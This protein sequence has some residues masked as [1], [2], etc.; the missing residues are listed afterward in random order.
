M[1]L[2]PNGAPP[3]Y[4]YQAGATAYLMD[5]AGTYSV[6]GATAPTTD[7]TGA[8]SG[9]GASAPTLAAAGAYIPVTDATSS[10]AEVIDPAGAYSAAGASAP[11]TDPADAYNRPGASAPTLAAG[12][13]DIPVAGATSASVSPPGTYLPAGASAP[14]P[15]PP[16]TYSGAGATAPTQ[17]PAGT[18]SGPYALDRLILDASNAA[19]TNTVLPFHSV[20]AVE[21]YFG[22]TSFE[23]SLAS[24]FFA[25]YAGS[26]AT[27][28]I[29]RYSLG[30]ERAHLFGANISKLKLSQL[31][32]ISG[33]LSIVF[34]GWAYS[35][36]I[37]LSGV[38]SFSAAAT[39]IQSA[40]N[41]SAPVAAMTSGSS[42][43]PVSVSFKGSLD[44]FLLRVT[45]V[46]SGRIEL[47]AQFSGPGIA[48]GAEIVVQNNGTPGG[49]GLYTLYSP[50]GT[51]SS[52][53]MTES[54]GV[55]TVGSV[56]SG[57]VADGEEVTGPGVASLTAIDDNL[58]GSGA[59]STWL[60]NNAQTVAPE[61]MT[62]TAT[63]LSVSYKSIVG[64][65]ANRDYFEVSTNGAFGF[66]QNPSSLS[67]MGGSA[68]A[69]LGLTQ[70]SEALDSTPGGEPTSAAAYMNN[71][72]QN[73][74]SQFGSF[75]AIWPQLAREDPEYL[76]DLAAWAQ[77]TDGL[78]QFSS[79][80]ETTTAAGSS[81][82]TPDPA[83]TYSGADASAPTPAAAGTYIPGTGATSAAAEITNSPGTYSLAGASAPTRAQPGYYVP[84]PGASSETPV[85]QGYY[86]P[87]S[88]ATKELLA[89][90]PTISGT[91]AGQTTGSGQPD[92]PFSSV[93]IKSRN[94][95]AS[96]S[97]SIQIT[98]GGGALADSAGFSGLTESAAGV[99]LLSGTDSAITSELDALV[100][101]PNTFSATTTLTLTDTT[102][103]G[104]SATDANTTVTVTNGEPVVVSVSTFLAEESTLNQQNPHG[105]D[106]L[107]SAANITAKLNQLD[108]S[109]ITAITIS[110]NG[111]VGASIQQLTTKAT[112]KAIGKLRNANLS[113]ALLAI[114]DTT[115]DI[116]AG[117]STLVAESDKIA[118][119]TASNGPMV[120]WAVTFLADQ[121]ALD[122]IVGGF[123]VLGKAANLAADLDRLNDP[124][125]S[126]ITISDNGEISASVAQL[127]AD[128]TAIGDLQNANGSSV[129]L[130][131]HDT[132][133]D[134]QTGLST[135]VQDAGEIGSITTSDGPIV[136]SVATFQDDQAALDKIVGGFDV[137][138]TAANIVANLSSLN[139]NSY[140]A[141][142][143]VDIGEASLSGGAVVN[144]RSFSESGWGTSLTVS[145]ALAYAG[146]FSQGA[147]STTTITAGNTLSLT[148]TASLSGTTSGLGTL[149]LAGGSATINSGAAVSVADLSISGSGAS[150]TL[151]EALTYAGAFSE[152][153]GDTLTLTGG[154]LALKGADDVF[155]G[156]TVD[157]SKFLDTEGTTAVSG[158]TIG[159]TVEWENTSAVT[160]SGG[161]VTLGDNVPADEAILY[162]T[163]KATYDILDDSGIGL[164][165]STASHIA[166]PGL[167]EKTG[168]TATSAIAPAVTN[169][170]TIEVAAAT[171]DFMGAVTGTGTDT[172]SGASTLEFDAAVSTSATVG[173]QNIGFTGGGTLDL[174]DPKAFWGEISGFATNDAVELLGSWAFSSFSEN[175]GGTLATLTLAS[176]AT[177]HAFDFVGDYTRGDFKITSGATSTITYG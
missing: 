101:T 93:T 170:G 95:D 154:A 27:L 175:S 30:G 34:Q 172:I 16:G 173:S 7:P 58:S 6:G 41:A 86:Q 104:T 158:L 141:A 29:S 44:G 149:A 145:E 96:D 111:N 35:A 115:A 19:P 21:N 136:V 138:D 24:D 9:P 108:D 103:V 106:I 39:A 132:A 84:G 152:A 68:A 131:I 48:A 148:G 2:N 76:D 64:E 164:G 123:D 11:T 37:N 4:Y 135:L 59:G 18:Y 81:S 139:A 40:L 74:N 51:T 31:K 163:A 119:I 157:G 124:N 12:G 50:G 102:S 134:V 13:A 52:E 155:S 61:P 32:G 94:I 28:L 168:G 22:K 105:F 72:V 65:T 165:A 1:S 10:A 14:M 92:T 133:G 160:Q 56:T 38:T 153:A 97:L 46:S 171:L 79:Q 140:V 114:T 127:T 67:Y 156:G 125:I 77:S 63:P 17:D 113:P 55:L 112:A 80:T 8:Y 43:A 60:V 47:G 122:K 73:E 26:P 177:K 49:P 110:D 161:N 71:L 128:A 23:A 66:D 91:M 3:G 25:G 118:S 147:G 129:L 62:N 143:T 150:V 159:G 85:S 174:T 88:G 109:D 75:Q 83:G 98:G 89:L 87:Y 69:T 82:P 33:S 107:D 42:I 54:Y 176:G 169:T 5:P 15:D 99:Y 142:I 167:F 144:A 117:L 126:G 162:N 137:S 116:Q 90:R 166:N 78:Y 57:T 20:T 120:V 70:A 146:A 151:G 36:S 130:A 100:F 53:T 45:S 121:S